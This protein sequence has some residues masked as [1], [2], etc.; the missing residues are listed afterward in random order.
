MARNCKLLGAKIQTRVAGGAISPGDLV[1][2]TTADVLG[3][4]LNGASG[5]GVE[6]AVAFDGVWTL[7]ATA[8]ETWVVDEPLYYD[9]G[10]G[11]LTNIAGALVRCGTCYTAKAALATTGD[12]ALQSAY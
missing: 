7:P 1:Y 8:A 5:I 3:V 12:I 2:D 9:P 6:H 4:S 11:F 10:T